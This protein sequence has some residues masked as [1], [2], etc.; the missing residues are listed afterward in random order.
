[1]NMD[2][3]A[4]SGSSNP[5]EDEARAELLAELRTTIDK[6]ERDHATRGDLKLVSRSLRELRYAF[7]VFT[8]YRRTKKVTVFG[9]ARTPAE[10][11]DFIAS[12]EFGARMAQQGWMVVTGAGGGIMEGAHLGAG[13]EM[14]MGVNIMLPFEQSANPVIAQDKKLV[15]FRYFFTRKLMFVKEVHAAALFPGGFGTQD[16]LFELLTLVQTGKRD[17]LPIVCVDHP[18]GTYW[19]RWLDFVKEQL[20]GRGLISPQDLA[21]FRVVD[22]VDDAVQEINQFYAVYHSMRYIRDQLVIRLNRMPTPELMERLNAEFGGIVESGRIEIVPTHPWEADD[23]DVATHPRIGLH[24]NR[25]DTGRLRQ[26]IDLLNREL[27]TAAPGPAG[28]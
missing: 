8:P 20:L 9:S 25:R 24:F 5:T 3:H 17:L 18:Q 22:S 23:H 10:H 13:K 28:N 21:L 11:P 26:M 12:R 27:A 6:L 14:S 1:M 4:S 2:G 7:H 16:E 15:T 19:K